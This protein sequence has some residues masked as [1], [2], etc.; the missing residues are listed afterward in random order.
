MKFATR[1]DLP[2]TIC[3][4]DV[5]TVAD[6]SKL[7]HETINYDSMS[8]CVKFAFNEGQSSLCVDSS[9][10]APVSDTVHYIHSAIQDPNVYVI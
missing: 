7:I 8:V 3:R 5:K 9:V 6:R 1:S 10:N 4:T 2:T